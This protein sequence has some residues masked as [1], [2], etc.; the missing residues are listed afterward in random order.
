MAP[1]AARTRLAMETPTP[2]LYI[3]L[4][5]EGELDSTKEWE[6]EV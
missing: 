2:R 3:P 4:E 1:R 5:L 6:I